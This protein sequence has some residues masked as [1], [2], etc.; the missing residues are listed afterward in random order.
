[1]VTDYIIVGGGSAGCAIAGRL[2]EMPDARV[3]LFET[4]PR[5]RNPYIHM[6]VTYFK[7]AKGGLLKRFAVSN[8]PVEL[9]PMVMVQGQVLGGGSS[10]NGMVYIRGCPED[11]DG[12]EALGC[13]GWGYKDVL[14]F[15]KRA[16]DNSRFSNEVHGTGGP[17]GVSDQ[18]HTSRLTMAWLQACQEAGLPYNP[19]FNSGAQAGCGLYQVTI[20]NGRRCSAAVAYLKPARARPNLTIRTGQRVTRIIIEGGRAVGVEYLERG[21]KAVLRAEAEVIICSGAIGS[22][23]LLMQSGI[24]PA[25]HLDEVGVAVV[26][27]LPGVGENLQDHVDMFLLH[28]LTGPYSYDKYKKFHWQAWAGLQY[29]MFGNGPVTSNVCEGG[30]FWW[31]HKS[32]KL[33][34]V[35]F[36]FL[37]GAGIETG[38]DTVPGGNGCTLNMCQTRPRS[39]GTVRLRSA[40]PAAA[41][42]VTPN[43]LSDPYDLDCMIEATKLGEDIMRQT[44]LSKYLARNHLPGKKLSTRQEYKEFV[45]ANAQGAL[46][47][48]GACRMGSDPMSVVDTS[49]RVH[50]LTGLRVADTSIMPRLISGNTNAPAIMIGERAA[51]FIRGNKAIAA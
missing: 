42:V 36:H 37:P 13:P 28:E 15:F 18:L 17:L 11:Y 44:A 3:T 19:D 20:R 22:P 4:G 45:L 8:G 6:P 24:G 41:P 39:R 50:G 49:L 2:S 9:S 16:E 1:M 32:D 29:A 5:D 12:W 47:P 23:K 14:P 21:R 31:G 51:S 35:Q 33:P 48:S 46:H 38:V 7:T 25:E 34:D 10:V 26:H 40:D 43:Y 30:A 27:D